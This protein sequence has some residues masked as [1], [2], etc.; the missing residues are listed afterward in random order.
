MNFLIRISRI[1][2][3]LVFVFSGFVKAVDPLG[4]TYKFIDYFNAFNMPW[5]E[6]AALPF[7]IIL[8]GSEFLI[9][10]CLL[11][12]IQNKLVNWGALIFMGIFT[13]LTLWLALE[14][15]FRTADALVMQ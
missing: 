5:L 12:F 10:I 11:L 2:V 4:S 9:G 3:G 6:P 7:S 13:P 1:I 15:P 14:N 8:S